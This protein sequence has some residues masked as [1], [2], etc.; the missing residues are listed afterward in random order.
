[1]LLA[2]TSA[3]NTSRSTSR[4]VTHGIN[5]RSAHASFP[6]LAHTPP[7]LRTPRRYVTPE[8]THRA[9][10]VVVCPAF[11]V[12]RT[13]CVAVLLAN[14]LVINAISVDVRER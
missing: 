8:K 11:Y 6:T 9:E 3:G 2:L 10:A 7:R 4:A 14:R 13:L 5:S 1:M 12:E